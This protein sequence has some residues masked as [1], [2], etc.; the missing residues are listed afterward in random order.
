VDPNAAEDAVSRWLPLLRA[1]AGFAKM[2]GSAVLSQA[3]LSAASFFV[4]LL[5]IR[6]TS[7][8]QYGYFILASN[9]VLLLTTLHSGFVNPALVRHLT[10]LSGPA[11]GNLVG[12][13][14]REQV[15]ALWIGAGGALALGLALWYGGLLDAQTGPLVLVTVGGICAVLQRNFFRMVLLA[16]RRPEVV[17]RNDVCY[18]ALLTAGT[19]LAVQ[20]HA[21][22]LGAMAAMAVAAA[23]GYALAAR[24][25]WRQET[26]NS[27][28]A[29]G[30]LR[31]IAPSASLSTAGAGI[32]WAFSQ[33]YMY[34]AA[35]LLDVAAV[36]A[37]A[38]TRLLMMPLNLLSTGIGALMLPLTA[39]W[40]Q[41]GGQALALRRL[42]TLALAMA[43]VAVG[44]FAVLWLLRDWIF[45]DILRKQFAHRD[46]LLALWA[47][48][49]LPMVVR[50][51][52]LYVLVASARFRQL[53][54]LG[55]M[56]AATSL[57]AGYIGMAQFGVL[58]APLGVLVG[59]SISL[60]GVIVLT[61]RVLAPAVSAP[62]VVT[63]AT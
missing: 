53:T 49:F 3:L 51:Q 54:A 56:V 37:I 46:T 41:R 19:A 25:L 18:V 2:M 33:G 8:L 12:G 15:R 60:L 35:G 26:W 20:A 40:L 59:E 23:V 42:W 34:L 14:Y 10:P 7:D 43:G 17:L 38:A 16:H 13:L 22:A 6:H 44:Y 36:A 11:R 55:S 32:H 57:L 48:A 47:L 29:P 58:G 5:L 27:A 61:L 30:I 45:A 21:A 52:L 50:D 62:R 4:G 31:T 24:A 39:G 28:G 1:Q 63:E 9:G